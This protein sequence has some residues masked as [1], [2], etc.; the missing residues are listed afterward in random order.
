MFD[1]G[2][3]ARPPGKVPAVTVDPEREAA[4]AKIYTP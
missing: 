4:C 2:S 1:F 3:T